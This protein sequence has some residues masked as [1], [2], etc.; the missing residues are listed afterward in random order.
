MDIRTGSIVHG[1]LA[2]ITTGGYAGSQVQQGVILRWDYEILVRVTRKGYGTGRVRQGRVRGVPKTEL[3]FVD[4]WD[5]WE[6]I[7]E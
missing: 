2:F 6:E 4:G 5:T 7:L 3:R 1:R